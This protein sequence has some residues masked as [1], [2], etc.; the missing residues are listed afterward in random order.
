MKVIKRNKPLVRIWMLCAMTLLLS[1]CYESKDACIDSR[2]TNYDV[3]GD[4]NVNV[5]SKGL[6]KADQDET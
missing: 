4:H 2:A 1:N 3:S 6:G 5:V